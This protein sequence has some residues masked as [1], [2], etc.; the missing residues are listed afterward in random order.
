MKYYTNLSDDAKVD[1]KNAVSYLSQFY[2]GTPLRFKVRL[3]KTRSNIKENP[4]MYPKYERDKR[5]RRAVIG[6]YI[7]LYTVNEESKAV[8]IYR[9]LRGS[10]DIPAVLN[11]Q[12]EQEGCT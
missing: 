10:L 6:D 8:Q 7:M 9:I 2:P 12:E 4:F 3:Q 5:Y 11:G 1:I